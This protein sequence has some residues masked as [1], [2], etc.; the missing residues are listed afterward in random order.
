M[1]MDINFTLFLTQAVAL[2][3]WVFVAAAFYASIERFIPG[4]STPD[5]V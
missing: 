3:A 1:T 4:Q 5:R 2:V